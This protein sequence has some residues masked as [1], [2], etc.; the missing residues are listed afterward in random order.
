M[1]TIKVLFFGSTEDSVIILQSLYD[2]KS[3][4][5]D[6]QIAAVVTQP[7]KPI[8]RDKVITPTPVETW[9][10][11]HNIPTLSFPAH[12][13]H[14]NLFADEKVAVDT[15]SPFKPDLLISASYGQKIPTETIVSAK[16]GGLNVHPSLLPRWRGADPVPWAIMTGDHQT[17]VS[18]VTLTE[19]FDEGK[20]IGQKKFP[21]TDKDFADP[22]RT[23]LFEMGADLLVTLLPDYVSGD[24]K[25]EAQ[26]KSDTPY[27]KR[28]TR[29]DGYE[30]WEN[31]QKALNDVEE[32]QR[33]NRKYRG[34]HPWPG[35]WTT[36]KL[37]NPTNTTNPTNEKRVKII[38]CHLSPATCLIIDTV[39]LEGKNPVSFDQFA[40][41]YLQ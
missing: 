10:K 41:A 21:I 4:T 18:V 8:G 7:P 20:I 34:L 16:Y 32:A 24:V 1:N 13:D 36:I 27:S 33:I 11:A 25:G 35:V 17:G 40:K 26:N 19:A 30:P 29:D 37:L 2:L 6:L 23:K 22:L 3:T 39:Q 9:A 38:T 15:L 14:P 28:F 12:S 31:I 5:Y